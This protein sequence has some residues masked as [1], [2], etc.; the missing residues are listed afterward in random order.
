MIYTIYMYVYNYNK[1]NVRKQIIRTIWIHKCKHCHIIDFV[2]IN[3]PI[4]VFSY[5]Y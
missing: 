5:I 4:N 3:I 2:E 1:I